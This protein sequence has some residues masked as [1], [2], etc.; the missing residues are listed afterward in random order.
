M[1]ISVIGTGYVGLV[2]GTCFASLGHDVICIDNDEKKI[3]EL[4]EEGILPIYEPD[5]EGLV[6]QCVESGKLT[7]TTDTKAAVAKSDIVFIAVGTPPRADNK[8]ADLKYVYQVA[9]EIGQAIDGYTVVVNKSTVPVGTADEVT[10]II[11]KFK[12][13][14]EFDVVSNPEFLREGF[15]IKDF[16]EGDR[17]AVGLSSEKARQ[18]MKQ[19]YLPLEQNDMPVI[20]TDPKSAEMA[21]Y[22]ANTALAI[23]ICFI[24]EI[25]DLCEKVGAN[26]EDVAYIMGLDSRIG[27][28]FLKTGPGFGGSC[29]PKDIMALE[30]TG[31]QYGCNLSLVKSMIES[32]NNRK[33]A[34]AEKISLALGG[35]LDGRT[36]GILGLA[37]KGNTDDC[38]ESPAIAIIKVLQQMGANIVAYDPEAM[39]EAKHLLNDISYAEDS[40]SVC[41]NAEALI[42]LTE[43]DEFAELDL[44]L[45]KSK[46]QTPM[47]ID[48]R[49]LYEP[50]E[51]RKQGLVYHSIGRV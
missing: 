26:I 29:F 31:R 5:L 13:E 35:D 11:K 8:Q 43:W 15:A 12:S 49:N 9:E 21:K 3:R 24:N 51:V 32:N 1:K 25:A 30:Y 19:V 33:Q 27:L 23:R 4:N 40:Y 39:D 34:M 37:F 2:S 47:L 45:V 42:I 50:S 28:K 7:F 6:T 38:R 44:Q 18:V 20:Y 17:V 16:L 22:A 36:I 14:D 41:D 46:L 10:E 48:L